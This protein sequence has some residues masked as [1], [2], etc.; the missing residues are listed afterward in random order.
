MTLSIDTVS[1][2]QLEPFNNFVLSQ[3]DSVFFHRPGWSTLVEEVYGYKAFYLQ[4]MRGPEIVGVLPLSLV[5]SPLTGRALISSAFS[6]GGGILSSDEDAR[7]ALADYAGN[8]AKEH[9]VSYVELRSEKATIGNWPQKTDVYAGFHKPLEKT[10][11]EMLTAIP[12]KRRAEI[13]KAFKF[14][15]EGSLICHSGGDVDRFYA[16]YA[17]ALRDLGTPVFPK[18]FAE[19][20]VARFGDD[21]SIAS[22]EYQG[23]PGSALI[24]FYHHDRVMPYYVGA[25][26]E[27]RHAR[28]FDYI[29]WNQMCEA[30]ERGAKVFDFGRSKF[31]AGSFGYKKTWGIEPAPLEYQYYLQTASQIPNVNPN[32]PKYA[33][34]LKVWKK[35]P[36]PVATFGGSLIARHFA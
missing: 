6:V 24:S 13:R 33:L 9:N 19:Q 7:S 29:Y 17:R 36:V 26:P 31:D 16:L 2:D 30:I 28:A 14:A 25:L 34:A 18:K 23:K 8:L 21:V 11:D 15:D 20:L 5:T 1:Q 12:R 4:A 27:A 3:P 35:L 22:V 10:E 32:N